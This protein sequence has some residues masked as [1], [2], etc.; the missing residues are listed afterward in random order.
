[1]GYQGQGV[2]MM[3]MDGGFL[4]TDSIKHF[5][6]AFKEHRILITRNFVQ[7][8]KSVFRS[9]SHG[10]LVLSDIASDVPGNLIGTAPKALYCLAYTEDGRSENRIEEDNWV[11]GLEWAD[12]LGCLVLNS[13]LGYTTFDDTT[14]LRN[15]QTL[16]G[17]TSHA[18]QAATIA[19]SKGIIICNSA[20]NSGD[21]KWKYLGCPADAKDILTI[22]AVDEKGNKASFSSFGP[23]ADGRVKPDACAV[24]YLA[25]G[26]NTKGLTTFAFGTS[27]SSPL[28]AGMVAC[29]R[30]A[31]PDKTNYEIM[32]AVRQ[33]GH[34]Y[35]TPSD[36]LGY[37]ITD[38]LKAYNLLLQ[39]HTIYKTADNNIS[40][41]FDSYTATQNKIFL[42]V[43]VPKET[44]MTITA[45]QRTN[46]NAVTKNIKLKKG[47]NKIVVKLTAIPKTQKFDIIDLKCSDGMQSYSFVVGNEKKRK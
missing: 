14:V 11:A 6:T 13:S 43:K 42:T 5:K 24:G 35:E 37:G 39:P 7:P 27:C 29:L 9:G 12:S 38:F 40:F 23:T 25:R 2:L 22:G 8:G 28:I 33:S 46:V 20:G 4:N 32:D 41:H 18:S 26:A 1:M 17:K 45:T 21:D 44:E 10:T 3:I 31:F 36:S 16:D 47:E 30:G 15:Y 34:T 19:A